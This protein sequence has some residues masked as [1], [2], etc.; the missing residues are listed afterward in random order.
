MF[1]VTGL[2][3]LRWHYLFERLFFV[4][5]WKLTVVTLLLHADWMMLMNASSQDEANRVTIACLAHEILTADASR[6]E[7]CL[8][9]KLFG[10]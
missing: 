1:P 10:G 4:T 9:R 6:F 7:S 2:F 3:I 8:S 5:F